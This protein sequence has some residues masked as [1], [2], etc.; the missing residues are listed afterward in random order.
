LSLELEDA[1]GVDPASIRLTVG[2]AGPLTPQSLAFKTQPQSRTAAPG[3]DVSLTCTVDSPSPPTFEWRHNGTPVPGPTSRN[4]FLPRVTSSHAGSY[5]VRA[6]AGNRTAGSNTATPTVQAVTPENLDTDGAGVN[7]KRETDP[8]TN[9]NAGPGFLTM[10][11]RG[12]GR[13]RRNRAIP[14]CSF[15]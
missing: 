10:P 14:R 1:T 8:G 12:G 5:F 13:G 7:D 3:D 4:L 9:P 2:S 6:K 11:W 15:P